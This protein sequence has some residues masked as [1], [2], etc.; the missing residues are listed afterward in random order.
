MS[1]NPN[2]TIALKNNIKYTYDYAYSKNAHRYTGN[3]SDYDAIDFF[4]SLVKNDP[5]GAFMALSRY[6]FTNTLKA[7]IAYDIPYTPD[8]E[9]Q[10]RVYHEVVK[11]MV[12]TCS[13][14]SIG[15]QSDIT[16]T[17][18]VKVA[19]PHIYTTRATME[20]KGFIERLPRNKKTFNSIYEKN[21]PSGLTNSSEQ[22]GALKNCLDNHISCLIGGAGTG[23]SYVTSNIV[24][25]LL[26]NKKKVAILAPTHKAKEALQSKLS[27]GNVQTIHS[28]VYNTNNSAKVDAIVIDEAGMLSTP[29]LSKLSNMYAGQQLVFVGDRNQIPPIEYGRPF[30]RIQEIF[31]T[32]ELKDNRRSESKDIIALGREII[33]EPFN[34]NIAQNNIYLVDTVGKAFNMGAE[35]LL[36][37]TND[38]VDKANELQR[39]KNG[40]PS[41]YSG[42]SV[43]DKI[44]A[45]T[46]TRA[47]FNGQLFTIISWNQAKDKS[48][49]IITFRA[50]YELEKNF[51]LAYGLTIHKSQ[52]SEWDTVAYQPTEKDKKNLAYVA[53]TRAKKK[54]IIVGGF[55]PQ[56]KEEAQ[57]V[58]L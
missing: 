42:Y 38:N 25:Q 12:D 51:D 45:K 28:F 20:V 32:I 41:I 39:I 22:F 50:P 35:V 47:Y 23:K 27:R 58:H 30:E 33:G 26:L 43:G 36:T 48:G 19:D 14:V 2:Y 7:L 11:D 10:A 8:Q 44:I 37:Y 57:W 40:E 52:G 5:F 15:Y 29:L 17:K 24:E 1:L 31:P 46:N 34:A 49:R 9:R 6:S 21:L 53:V 56:F 3:E 55:P 16:N 54:L 4:N 18:I 13:D